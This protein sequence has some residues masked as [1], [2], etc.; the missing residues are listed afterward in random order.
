[1]CSYRPWKA[2]ASRRRATEPSKL[3][4]EEFADLH[5]VWQPADFFWAHFYSS[6]KTSYRSAET[7]FLAGSKLIEIYRWILN[8]WGC[9]FLTRESD[10]HSAMGG[11]SSKSP[12]RMPATSPAKALDSECVFKAAV[13][14]YTSQTTNLTTTP[15]VLTINRSDPLITPDPYLLL[16]QSFVQFCTQDNRVLHPN[17][18]ALEFWTRYLEVCLPVL[19]LRK[20]EHSKWSISLNEWALRTLIMIIEWIFIHCREHQ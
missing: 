6:N 16:P 14:L 20:V 13:F 4:F 15:I 17:W 8:Q 19:V 7:T 3:L 12:R 5:A 18:S 10:V 11:L 2:F 9:D 1:M